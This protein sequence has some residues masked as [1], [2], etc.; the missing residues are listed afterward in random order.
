[1]CMMA[2]NISIEYALENV[3][4]TCGLLKEKTMRTAI[5]PNISAYHIV[6]NVS[7]PPST[8]N[9]KAVY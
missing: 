8:I 4:Q 2:I 9:C 7:V 3:A 1:M 6:R 5:D